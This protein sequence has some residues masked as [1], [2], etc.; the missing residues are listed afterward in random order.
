MMFH[1]VGP[2]ALPFANGTPSI[3]L[4]KPSV[5]SCGN[6]RLWQYVSWRIY[7]QLPVGNL[8]QSAKTMSPH[9]NSQGGILWGNGNNS[10][11]P[12]PPRVCIQYR[13]LWII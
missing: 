11:N 9:V 12:S 8:Q 3:C 10:Q 7:C 2:I 13:D 5:E 4:P 1:D 6:L